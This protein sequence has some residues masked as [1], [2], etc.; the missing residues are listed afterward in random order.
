MELFFKRSEQNDDNERKKKCF[1]VSPNEHIFLASERL[2]RFQSFD[3][4]IVSISSIYL[5][6]NKRANIN[7]TVAIFFSKVKLKSK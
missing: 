1:K 6:V 7:Y 3:E 4:S 2:L 5:Q